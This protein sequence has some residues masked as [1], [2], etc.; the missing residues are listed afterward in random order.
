MDGRLRQGR[1][2]EDTIGKYIP[3]KVEHTPGRGRVR[4]AYVTPEWGGRQYGDWLFDIRLTKVN[5]SKDAIAFLESFYKAYAYPYAMMAPAMENE[6]E[7]LRK[8]Y[9]MPAMLEKYSAMKKELVDMDGNVDPLI[10]C[11]DFDAFW[12]RTLKVES[13]AGGAFMVSYACNEDGWKV[14]LK[15]TVAKCDGL[16]RIADLDLQ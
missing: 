10:N 8:T 14:Q 2:G 7:L 3:I 9:C 13:L 5:D 6:L 11:S 16:F 12:Y 1:P 4:I 15:V